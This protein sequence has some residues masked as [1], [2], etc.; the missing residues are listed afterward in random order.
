[1]SIDRKVDYLEFPAADLEAIKSFYTK[2][3]GW[4]FQDYGDEYCAFN[5]G[6]LDGGFYKADMSSSA[7]NGSALVVIYAEDLE[8]TL[9]TIVANGG[10]VVR[11][12]FDFPGGRRF[13]FADPNGNEL[14]VWSN[15]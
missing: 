5:D 9:A 12:I 8:A 13:H 10:T 15:K 2:V 6:R 7:A 4:S 11:N 3:F 1:M 14:A